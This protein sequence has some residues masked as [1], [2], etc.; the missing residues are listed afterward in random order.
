LNTSDISHV[1]GNHSEWQ[2]LGELT[3]SN[4]SADKEQIHL[5]LTGL[6]LSL[7]LHPDFLDRIVKSAQDAAARAFQNETAG[8]ADH[9]HLVIYGPRDQGTKPGT[10]GFFRVEK[11]ENTTGEPSTA[12]HSVEFYLYREG[13]S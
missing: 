9:I 4:E 11:V 1:P 2:S 10:W 13:Q 12:A 7:S 6:L 3:L 8:K 5:W